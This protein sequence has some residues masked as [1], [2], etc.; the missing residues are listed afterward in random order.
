MKQLSSLALLLAVVIGMQE[1]QE[2]AK[3]LKPGDAAPTFRLNNH[4]GKAISIGG[5]SETWTV[6]AFFPK[7][8]TPG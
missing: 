5:K 4:T 8:A 2:G 6:L 3:P 7:A 1:A